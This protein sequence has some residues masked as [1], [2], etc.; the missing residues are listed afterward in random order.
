MNNK[1]RGSV[2][3]ITLALLAALI[4]VLAIPVVTGKGKP[5][6]PGMHRDM[7]GSIHQQVDVIVTAK[8]TP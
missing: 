1:Q 8:P 4:V 7:R 2:E 6:M 3:L 5:P